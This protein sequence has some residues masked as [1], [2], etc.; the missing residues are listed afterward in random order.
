VRKAFFC[1]VFVS[2]VLAGSAHAALIIDERPADRLGNTLT[3]GVTQELYV[4]FTSPADTPIRRVNWWSQSGTTARYKI[5]IY[6]CY[7]GYVGD[8]IHVE[9]FDAG[10]YH[11]E[12]AALSG[13]YFFSAVFGEPATLEAGED[14]FIHILNESDGRYW[15]MEVTY[16][17]VD[18][19]WQGGV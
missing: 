19:I 4:S 8:P 3:A 5:G 11:S 16:R 6:D 12:P 14:Y 17:Y 2:F 18:H 7:Y 1:A 15:G 13:R 9:W 10:E